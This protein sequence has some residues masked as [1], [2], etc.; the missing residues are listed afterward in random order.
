VYTPDG[1]C[2]ASAYGQSNH[3]YCIA[4]DI[5][6]E[7][8]KKLTNTQLKKFGLKKSVSY[9]PWHVTLIELVGIS[10][11]K[12]EQI[13]DS[14]LNGKVDDD[15]TVKEFQTINGLDADG[16]IGSKTK[17]KA[18]EMLQVCQEIL[19]QDYKNANEAINDC[20]TKPSTWLTLMSKTKYFD[21]FVMNIVNKLCG[22]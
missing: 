9:E 20:M 18:K 2:W 10:Q 8:F 7:W 12:K 21:S 16:I 15:M 4:M 22:K 11:E 5:S 6:D 19:G 1:K 3:N 14:V 13:R 17:N